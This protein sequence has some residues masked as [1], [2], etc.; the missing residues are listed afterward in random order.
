MARIRFFSGITT[1]PGNGVKGIRPEWGIEVQALRKGGIPSNHCLRSQDFTL[2][3]MNRTYPV[4]TG[5]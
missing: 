2:P 4:F 5:T 1:V 3:L